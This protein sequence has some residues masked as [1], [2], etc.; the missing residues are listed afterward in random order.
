MRQPYQVLV[1][2]YKKEG[3][4]CLFAIFK[5]A[6]LNFWQWLSGGGKDSETAIETAKRE[7]LEETSIKIDNLIALD[8]LAMIPASSVG[9]NEWSVYV[10]PEYC[11]AFNCKEEIRI[12]EE[13]SEYRWVDYE[14]AISLLKY[15]SNKT[16]LYELYERIKKKR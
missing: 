12:G 7:A 14:T 15:D 13:H 1:I 8:S 3:S 5:R 2:P 9:K 4:D 10:V 6:D 16:S 11:F